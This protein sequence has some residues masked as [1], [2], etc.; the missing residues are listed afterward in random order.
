MNR[1]STNSMRGVRTLSMLLLMYLLV[2]CETSGKIGDGLGN[3]GDKA[4]EVIGFKKP[5]VPQGLAMPEA[6]KPARQVD[7]RIAASSSLNTD[8]HGRSLSVIVRVYRL[9][10]ANAF[11]NAPY[12]TFGDPK[13]EKDLLGDELV[14]SRELLL[15]P[16]QQKV[17]SERWDRTAAYIGVV[18]LFIAPAPQ[19]WRYA[20]A[21]NETT[22]SLVLGAHACGLSVAVGEPVGLN[23]HTR[24]LQSPACPS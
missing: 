2:G 8:T 16:S 13:K 3:M 24:K 4:L 17:L 7:V 15:L 20:F 9:R 11:L 6:A 12:D 22:T 14:E 19:Q 21:L 10:G 5:D 18:A 23:E 1:L